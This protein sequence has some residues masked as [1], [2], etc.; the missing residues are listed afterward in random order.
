MNITEAKKLAK[1]TATENKL[2]GWRIFFSDTDKT[3]GVHWPSRKALEFSKPF[4]DLN[5]VVVC[6]DTILHEIAH[7]LVGIE[8]EQNHGH[9]EIWEAKCKEIGAIP[10]AVI[11]LDK[12]PDIKAA[13][14]ATDFF[15]Q[16]WV[17]NFMHYQY[18]CRVDE[19]EAETIYQKLLGDGK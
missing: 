13:W 2:F 19:F 3:C 1:D 11:D 15:E 5:S 7:A 12:R 17:S 18:T 10:E 8:H 4:F 14:T 16:M 9:D 6:K